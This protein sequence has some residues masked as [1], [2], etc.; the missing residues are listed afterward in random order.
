MRGMYREGRYGVQQLS[1]ES[2]TWSTCTIWCGY[3]WSAAVEEVQRSNAVS[4]GTRTAF[5]I[6]DRRTGATH[7]V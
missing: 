1:P 3:D 2:Q 4:R 7:V 5:R 6:I